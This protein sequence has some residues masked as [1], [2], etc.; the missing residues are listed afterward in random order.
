LSDEEQVLRFAQDDRSPLQVIAA[1]PRPV[2]SAANHEARRYCAEQLRSLGF[3]VA[4]RPF[5]FSALPG[6]YA[7]QIIGALAVV[8]FGGAYVFFATWFTQ[9]TVIVLIVLAWWLGSARAT[10]EPWFRETGINLEATRGAVPGV[11]LVAHID[12]KSQGISSALRS[13]GVTLLVFPLIAS[14]AMPTVRFPMAIPGVL[15]GLIL[16]FAFVSDR[17]DGAADNASGVAAVLEAVASI[18]R[19]RQLGVLITD[20]EELALAGAN[21]WVVGRP[22]GIAINCDTIDDAG[23]LVVFEYGA[24]SHE[25]DARAGPIAREVDPRAKVMRPPWGV[26][27][28]SNAFQKAGWKTVT[29]ARGTIR[30]LNRIH[31]RRDSLSNLRG[32][33]IPDAARVLARLVEELS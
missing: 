3:E 28:D 15:G 7:A 12:S 13:I 21:A 14:L 18:P 25:L 16:C 20:A 31:T 26:L 1:R 17:S 19:D 22:A 4:E 6:R 32:T 11:W 23:Q 2:G 27:T 33:G 9:F 8:G 29:L 10:R 5:E 24:R 30:T